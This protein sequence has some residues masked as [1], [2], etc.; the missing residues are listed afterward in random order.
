MAVG[1]GKERNE[2]RFNEVSL[3]TPGEQQN[4]TNVPRSGSP[5]ARRIAFQVRESFNPKDVAMVKT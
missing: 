1:G 5:S 2:G 3:G 4:R